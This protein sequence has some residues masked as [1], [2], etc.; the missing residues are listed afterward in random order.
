MQAKRGPSIEVVLHSNSSAGPGRVPH[1]NV[2]VEG[3]CALDGRLVDTGIL[4]DGV[5]GSVA[6]DGSLDGTLCWVVVVVLHDVVLNQW[7]GAPAIDGKQASSA[8]DTKRAAKV[9]GTKRSFWSED[10][11]KVQNDEESSYAEDPVVQPTPTTK[12][13]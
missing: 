13:S 8:V 12:S 3:R 7:V 5:S 2:L 11:F 10:A 1:G 6:G 4:P 9:D